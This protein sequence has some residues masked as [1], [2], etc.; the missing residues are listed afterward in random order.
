MTTIYC[1]G[2]GF[3][4]GFYWKQRF[5]SHRLEE[6]EDLFAKMAIYKEEVIGRLV[7]IEFEI[8]DD[9]G[10]LAFFQ[11]VITQYN[12]FVASYGM[13]R[14]HLIIFEDGDERWFNLQDEESMG[15]LHWVT[16]VTDGTEDNS[17]HQ[18][19]L[20]RVQSSDTI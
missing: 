20:P 8:C 7:M 3:F 5:P 4:V 16:E 1:S 13:E 18:F 15:R 19:L 17:R 2:G 14:Q 11:G 9:I 6:L 10:V 12:A